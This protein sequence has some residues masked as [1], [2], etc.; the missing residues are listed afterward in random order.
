MTGESVFGLQEDAETSARAFRRLAGPVFSAL[1]H[2]MI[3]MVATDPRMADNPIIFANAAFQAMTG[4]KAEEL[5]GRNCRILQGP[6]TDH[7]VVRAIAAAI[8]AEGCIEAEI[9]N[10]RKDG[11]EFWN[12]ICIVPVPDESGLMAFFLSWQLDIT[13]DRYATLAEAER[14]TREGRLKAVNESLQNVLAIS[15]D[16]ATW[17]WQIA[18]QKLFGDASFAALYGLSPE[19]MEAGVPANIF[20]SRIH[21]RDLAR[22]RLAVGGMLR[23]AELFSR[24][25]RIIEPGGATRWVHGRGR[26]TFDENDRPARFS[27]VLVDITEQKRLEEKLR[28]AQSAGGVG[29]FEHIE[30][31]ATVSVSPQFCMLLGLHPAADLPVRT[32]NAVVHPG[33]PAIIDMSA[34]DG[35]AARLTRRVR[36][37]LQK[38][39]E[40]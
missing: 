40:N 35:N 24:E 10:Y 19:V 1:Q 29:T 15:G 2:S 12:R 38:L 25:F 26:C 5:L 30:G 6:A 9:L 27:G 28:I 8:A 13:A 16:A 34:N 14:Q 39:G 36:D 33:D 21:P 7:H 31:F 3:A 22:T 23:G 4:H 37:F 32:L 20:F 18:D 11:S 17:E